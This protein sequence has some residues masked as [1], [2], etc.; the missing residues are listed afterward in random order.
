MA[1]QPVPS[2][3]IAPKIPALVSEIILKLLAK[4][5]K[6]RYQSAWE[7]KIDLEQCLIQLENTGRIEPFLLAQQDSSDKFY[8]PE[9]LYIPYCR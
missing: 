4:T 7:I 9:K 8:I 6:D 5:A 2:D 1:L 3:T